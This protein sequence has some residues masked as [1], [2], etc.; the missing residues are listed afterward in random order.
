MKWTFCHTRDEWTLDYELDQLL[1]C[2]QPSARIELEHRLTQLLYQLDEHRRNWPDDTIP[3]ECVL[4]MSSIRVV[5]HRRVNS[6][7]QRIISDYL[8]STDA[9]CVCTS[10]Y[11]MNELYD[12][13]MQLVKYCVELRPLGIEDL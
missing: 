7:F 9:L 11:Q 2:L 6:I 10:A 5:T 8:S 12:R 13:E 3:G 4:Y 1:R